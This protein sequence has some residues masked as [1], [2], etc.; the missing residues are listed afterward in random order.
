MQLAGCLWS[1]PDA[2][3]DAAAIA[4]RDGFDAIDVDPGFSVAGPRR[5]GLPV[6]CVAVAHLM[7]D[8]VRLE[9]E[10]DA[11]R[12]AAVSH[13]ERALAEAA[14][15][16]AARA[17]VGPASA[18]DQS[19]R[20][21]YRISVMQLADAAAAHGIRLGI[22]HF[23]NRG[24]PTV[25]STLAFI[26]DTGH[27]NL[28]VLLDIGHCLITG[29]D[30]TACVGEAGDRLIYVHA[31]DNDGTSDQHRGLYDGLIQPAQV[32]ALF[33][34][35]TD[36]GYDGAIGVET[37]PHLDDPYA[38]FRGTLHALREVLGRR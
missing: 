4:E 38:A 20:S 9:A 32:E 30:F 1:L 23:P 24:L 27:P 17:Y 22:E 2:P 11:V 34:A 16:G 14:Q 29:E 37:N 13:V 35:L 21:R 8:G 6:S 10:D 7:A 26:R 18:T 5:D 25:A 12:A 19:M 15:L 3:V 36:H 28:Y 31:D 33:G